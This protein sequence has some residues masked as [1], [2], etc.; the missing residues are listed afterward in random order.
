MSAVGALLLGIALVLI[1]VLVPGIPHVLYLIL[2]IVGI[3][4]A[5]YGLF[6]LITS[7]RSGRL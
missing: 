2:L 5:V 7:N 1:A 3:L 6:L 4:L